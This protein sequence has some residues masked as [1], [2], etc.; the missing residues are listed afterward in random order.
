MILTGREIENSIEQGLIKITPFNKNHIGPNSLDLTLSDELF[1][2]TSD[3]DMKQEPECQIVKIPETG[4]KLLPG[5][6]YLGKTVERTFTEHF[7]PQIEGRSSIARLGMSIHQS[8]GFGDIGFDG[9]WTLEIICSLPIIVYPNV[10]ICQIFFHT[11]EGEVIDYRENGK[12]GGNRI[13]V[14]QL[15]KDFQ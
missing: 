9:C 4:L 12:Y 10:R 3:L 14:S 15:Y 6:F 1:V 13:Q 2:Y 11:F 8:A 5:E 7:V